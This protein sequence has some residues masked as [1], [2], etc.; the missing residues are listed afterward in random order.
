MAEHIATRT[1]RAPFALGISAAVAVGLLLAIAL[2]F[3]LTRPDDQHG[4]AEVA[5]LTLSYLAIPVQLAFVI[6]R[7]DNIHNIGLPAMIVAV[8][9]VEIGIIVG[10]Y[11]FIRQRRR[12]TRH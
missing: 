9:L 2:V 7:I 3:V 5:R 11:L 12:V 6:L 1:D 8:T 4:F 10:L